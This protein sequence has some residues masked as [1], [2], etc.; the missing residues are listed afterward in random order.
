M[1]PFTPQGIEPLPEVDLNIVG[2]SVFGR[3]NKISSELTQNMFISDNWL[4]NFAGW[5]QIYN[6]LPN[7]TIANQGRGVYVSTRGN[8]MIAVVN[9]Q[10]FQLNALLTPI[11]IGT[12]ATSRGEVFIDE[13]LNSQICIVDGLHAYIYNWSTSPNLT[14]QTAGD[15]G[16]GNLIPNY[17]CYHNTFFLF[18]NA[19]KTGNGAAWYA[20]S[21]SSATQIVQ[22]TQLALQTKPDYALAVVRIPAQGNNVLVLG[23]TVCEI[24]T[25]VGG[26][27]NY[28]RNS[29]I[30]VD[31]GCA[32]VSTIASSDRYVAWL[33]INEANAPVIMVYSG[34][35][36][37]PIS[38]DGIDYL[39]SKIQYPAQ[40]TAMFY[41]QDGHLFYQLTF[42][43]TVDNL[44]IAYDFTTEKFF[45]LT[46]QDTNYHPARNFVY[47]NN[48]IYFISLNNA[49]LYQSSTDFTS[50]DENI[51]PYN[52]LEYNPA[53]NADIP[54]VRIPAS[55]RLKNN[56][57]FICDRVTLTLEQGCDPNVSVASLENNINYYV[58]ED[59]TYADENIYE[60]AWGSLYVTE[61]SGVNPAGGSNL[62]LVIIPPYQPRI[63]LCL[64]VDGGITYGNYVSRELNPIGYRQNI[65]SW[66]RLGLANDLTLKFKFWGNSRFILN[67][68][69]A[70]LYA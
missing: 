32:S 24:W 43:N 9:A 38:T 47:F 57:R 15:L 19:N 70:Y 17:V 21:Y 37:V 3:Y 10:V 65:M 30:N 52:S 50:Y 55:I 26:L 68:G 66:D 28:R 49:S 64:S 36:N 40:S 39:L 62:G 51:L 5:K 46:D 16:N 25:Q 67:N 33:G 8:L 1:R 54:R 35:G 61:D 6:L 23:S 22:T 31:Y 7:S 13:N 63:D 14:I 4:V 20:Y 2:S 56:T 58:T 34:Q 41:R 11:L 48:N 12:L 44:T 18:G 45:N 59:S 42:Y 60:T 53:L 27:Q 69:S 29:T